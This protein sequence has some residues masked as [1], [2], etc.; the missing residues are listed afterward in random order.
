MLLI[1]STGSCLLLVGCQMMRIVLILPCVVWL[2][3]WT[4]FVESGEQP[5]EATP[6]SA[7]VQIRAHLEAGE[8]GPARALTAGRPDRDQLLGQIATFQARSGMRRAAV[9]TASSMSDDRSRSQSLADIRN[10]PSES[11]AARGGAAMADFDSLIEL[12]TSTIAP[13]SWDEVGGN[14]AVQ[15][16]ASGVT[17]D[18]AGLLRRISLRPEDWMLK[19]QRRAAR[20]RSANDNVHQ[21]SALRKISLTRLEKELQ[22][23]WASGQAPDAAMRHL[24]GMYKVK[25][26]FVYPQQGEIVLAGPAGPW[27]AN[28]LGR[29]V[30]AENGWPVLQLDDLVVLVR[31]AMH[32][33]G[34]FGCSITPTRRGLAAAKEFQESS[35][36]QGPLRSAKQRR[37]WL[38]QLQQS[39]GKQDISV[40]GID[41][42][43]RVAH[44]LVEADYRMKRVGM[45]LEEGVLGVRS[46]LDSM[47]RDPPGSMSVIRWWFT[48]NYKAIQANPERHAFSFHGPGV[49]VLSENEFLTRQG[50][51]VHT[52]KSDLATAEFA[53]SFTR[54]FL[55]LA[56]KHP[57][58]AELKNV[59]DLA[60]VAGLLQS[61]DLAG[62]VDWHLTHWG[63]PDQYQVVR[64]AVPRRVDTIINHRL[65]G[66]RVIAGV[67]G[68]V[69]VDTA[70]WVR[71]DAIEV[72]DYGALEAEH[73]TA[74]PQVKSGNAWWWD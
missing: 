49:K 69:T 50:K 58:Y 31:N 11:A 61:E 34:S 28:E 65:V 6:S 45:G 52:G 18:T 10:P 30:N 19:E 33:K 56:K 62:Q 38:N 12:I 37:T 13:D 7:H 47:L 29:T 44:I 27:R 9:R 24:A 67:S 36:E 55:A 16:F 3:G 70:R 64:G 39:L 41:P 63:D 1:D 40:Y 35:K 20:E 4:E 2:L 74:R 68:G 43:T 51:R 25:Y 72:D 48:L 59:F 66:N 26:V 60:L 53:E 23:R 8:F 5:V 17:V 21:S 22:I 42:R 73:A 54:N 14:G 15:E 46:V 32:R 71:A 57:I